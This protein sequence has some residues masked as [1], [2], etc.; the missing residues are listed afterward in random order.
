MNNEDPV[1][2]EFNPDPTLNNIVA[3]YWKFTVP[4][5]KKPLYHLIPPDGCVSLTFSINTNI[6]FRLV[7][8]SG[9]GFEMKE[10]E[11]PPATTIVGIRFLPGAFNCVFDTPVDTIRYNFIDASEDE[12]LRGILLE[13][14][15]DFKDI[16]IFNKLLKR[17]FRSE[18][19]STVQQAVKLIVENRGNIT[20][21]Q[22]LD[23]L[24]QSERQFQRLFK[25]YVGVSA[26]E[27]VKLIKIRHALT[28][29]VTGNNNITEVALNNGYFDSSHFNRDLLKYSRDSPKKLRAYFQSIRMKALNW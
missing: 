1:Y 20:I 29:L 13:M 22:L 17:R 19:D 11:I 12:D 26:R 2:Q 16:H 27:L 21:K 8:F 14:E 25:T 6:P 23:Q 15:V 10:V 9:A 28:E 7:E 18:P 3:N 24:G 5:L 4:S